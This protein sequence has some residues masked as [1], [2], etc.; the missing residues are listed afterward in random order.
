MQVATIEFVEK[1]HS[2]W[3]ASGYHRW[4]RGACPG[5]VRQIRKHAPPE[6]EIHDEVREDGIEAHGFAD[7][8][9]KAGDIVKRAHLK[10]R[11]A[12]ANGD[13]KMMRHV[14]DYVDYVDVLANAPDSQ[15]WSEERF[16]LDWLATG[17]DE[18]TGELTG[19]SVLFGTSDA[20]VYSPTEGWLD[21]VNNV[22]YEGP[23]LH[24]VDL[25]YGFNRVDADG[26]PQALY[27]ALG[28][29][30][31]LRAE[32]KPVK[33][34]VIHLYQPRVRGL[35][36][37]VLTWSCDEAYLESFAME[38][39]EDYLAT[40]EPDAPLRAEK[41]HCRLCRART[42]CPELAGPAYHVASA[43][44]V[45]KGLNPIKE[46]GTLEDFM[47]NRAAQFRAAEL[48]V[49]WADGVQSR[50]REEMN[51]G[52]K[53]EGLKLVMGKGSR[54]F[55]ALDK[56]VEEFPRSD[57]PELYEEPELRSP[58]QVLEELPKLGLSKDEVKV[59]EA[60]Y[61]RKADGKPLVALAS[62]ARKEFDPM[63]KIRA[64]F[65]DTFVQQPTAAP[66][67]SLVPP[68]PPMAAPA[69]S[70]FAPPPAIAY[71]NAG[72]FNKD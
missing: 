36:G 41:S 64:E 68:P 8:L 7:V 39:K 28:A 12:N 56:F 29:Y 57:W 70:I 11:F 24:V 25:K 1:K 5:S 59:V 38:L 66:A 27:Y 34:I 40:L 60:K 71:A 51:R 54:Y 14:V 63:A 31:R 21:L 53:Y 16:N 20:V 45:E 42:N 48:A 55:V 44:L 2:Q 30:A 9:Q 4:R 10:A 50:T 18:E 22:Q 43:A 32:G 62:D 3:G 15:R 58:S 69:V 23:I 72:I 35:S 19:E 17:I 26:N 46:L 52:E 65:A 6:L 67:A 47:E 13:H 49:A 37:P 61:V 33:R